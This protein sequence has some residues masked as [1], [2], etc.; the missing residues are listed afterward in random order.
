MI[1]VASGL[2]WLALGFWGIRRLIDQSVEPSSRT[3][4]LYLNLVHE[5]DSGL[6]C[7]NLRVS[8][9]LTRPILTGLGRGIILIP[10][11]LNEPAA[12][13]ES[14]R[15]ILLHELA[16]AGQGDAQLNAT[17]SLAQCLWFFIPYAWWLRT[18]L[19]IDQEFIADQKT[20]VMIGSSAGYATRLV[21]LAANDDRAPS[22]LPIA[23][24]V[25]LLSGW[26]WD[27]G[28]KTPLLQRVVMLLHAPFPI[29][30]RASRLWSS[31][32]PTMALI[33]AILASSLTLFAVP[34]ATT[35]ANKALSSVKG[36]GL[37]QVD[38]FVA[39][40]RVL[41]PS[42]RS[43][44]YILPLPLPS[45]FELSLEIEAAHSTLTQ[46][47]VAGYSL[48][49]VSPADAIPLA[50]EQDEASSNPPSPW[51]RV[52]LRRAKGEVSLFVNDRAFSAIPVREAASDWLTIEPAPDQSA[53]IHDLT[54]SW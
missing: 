37:F 10:A 15:L 4:E 51:Y 28:L 39:S 44:A 12:D 46:M 49:A 16:H 14:L 50:A 31:I 36:R 5:F 38:R 53:I 52:R 7:P 30:T 18:Q 21:A 54:V 3:Q 1:G 45:D 40:P 22:L 8:A 35:T 19:R 33:T 43:P 17:S 13:P 23:D 6:P 29:E 42:G 2:A 27:G 24:S 11:K 48:A 41:S 9:T 34:A 26:W 32:V 47:S 25:P 20:V